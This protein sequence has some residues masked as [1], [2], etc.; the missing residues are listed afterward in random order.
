MTPPAPAATRRRGVRLAARAQMRLLAAA[1]LVVVGSVL[2]WVS[3]PFGNVGGLRGA[4]LWT[5]YAG[6]AG[7]AGALIPSRRLALAHA[8][9]L[10]AVATTLPAWQFVRLLRL[11]ADTGSFTAAV[12]GLG[13]VLAATG[14][15][16]AAQAAVRLYRER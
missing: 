2:P 13:L 9:V 16:L 1:A 8:G 14:G 10:A 12:P 6:I 5:L 11:G 3:T 15:V 7:I 4:G